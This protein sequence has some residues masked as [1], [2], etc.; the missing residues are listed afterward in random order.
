MENEN[1]MFGVQDTDILALEL[2]TF[3]RELER[4]YGS[5]DFSRMLLTDVHELGIRLL[6]QQEFD[7]TLADTKL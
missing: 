5:K 3:Y 6:G 2:A 1:S 4:K 7:A